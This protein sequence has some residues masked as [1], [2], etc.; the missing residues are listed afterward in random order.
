MLG[1]RED[2]EEATQDIFLKAHR[3]L[4]EFRG[5]SSVR[6]WLYRITVNTCLTRLRNTSNNRQS[7]DPEGVETECQGEAIADEG[8]NPETR[9]IEQDLHDF[10][11]RA[12]ERISAE[13]KEILILYHMDELKYEEIAGV[14]GVPIGTVCA[15]IYRA[16]KSLRSEMNYVRKEVRSS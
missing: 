7:T 3:G 5:E 2:A 9:F 4:A 10:V 12:L 16:R 14:L 8:G 15:R 6:T 13:E 1:N 11:L